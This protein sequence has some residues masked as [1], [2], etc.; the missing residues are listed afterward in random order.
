MAFDLNWFP[1]VYK[2]TFIEHN[3]LGVTKTLSTMQYC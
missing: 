2:A 1:L 3:I